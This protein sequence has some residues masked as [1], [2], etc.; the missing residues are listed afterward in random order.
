MSE[1]QAKPVQAPLITRPGASS[2][3]IGPRNIVEFLPTIFQTPANKQFLDATLEQLMSTGSLMAIN[4]FLGTNYKKSAS[5]NYLVDNRA[6]DFYQFTPGVTNRDNENNITQALSYD[7]LINTLDFNEV[8]TNQ[9]NK[10]LNEQGYTLDMPINYDMFINYHN[11]FWLVDILPPC[12]IKPTQANPIDI[13]TLVDDLYYTTPTLSTGN[14]LELMNGMR[15][16]FMPTQIDRFTQTVPGN[17]IFTATVNQ[18]NTVKV[19]KNNQLLEN[20]PSNYTYNTAGGVVIFAVAPAVNDEIEIHSFYAYSSSNDYAVGDIYIV[21]GVGDEGKIR[22][23]KQFTSGQVEGTYSTR[24]WLNHTVYSS[25]EPKGFDEDGTSFEFDPYDIREWRMTTRD[26]VVEKRYSQDVSAWAR[27]NLWIHETAAQAVVNFEGLDQS[28]YLADNFRGVRP[29]IEYKD[30]IEKYNYGRNHIGYVAHLIEDTIDPATQIVGQ[31]IYSHNTYGIT[32]DWSFILGYENGDRVRVNMGGYITYWECIQTHGDPINPT[33]YESRKYWRE[34]TDENLEDGDLVLFLRTTN[35]AYTNRIFRVD[36]VTAGTGI[37]LTEVYGSSSTPLNSGDKVVVMKGYNTIQW[38]DDESTKPYSGSEWYWDGTDWIYGQQKMHRSAGM[39][40]QLYDSVLTKLD[41]T[42]KYPTSTFVGD[43][44]FD[45]GKNTATKF[46]D[47]LGF[48]PRYVDYGNTPGLSFDFGLGGVRYNYTIYDTDTDNSKTL[49]IPGYY[50]YK[51]YHTNRYFNGWSAVRGGQPVRRHIQKIAKTGDTSLTFNLGTTDYNKDSKLSFVLRNNLLTVDSENTTRINQIAGSLPTLYMS[52]NATYDIETYFDQTKLEFL[53]FD[54]SALAPADF[55]RTAGSDNR[56]TVQPLSSTIKAI[57]YRHAD[58]PTVKGAVYFDDDT[59]AHNIKVLK[60]GADYTAFT[61]ASNILTVTGVDVDDVFDVTYHSDSKLSEAEGNFMP[62]DTHIY[63]PQNRTLVDASFG[64]LVAHMREQMQGIPNFTGDYFGLN[65]YDS[66]A[67]THQFGGTIRQQAFSTELLG[68]TSLDTDTDAFSALKYSAQE[69]RRFKSQFALKVAQLHKITKIETPIHEIVDQ[70]L[71]EIHIGKNFDSQFANSNMAMYR[72]YQSQ[73]YTWINTFTPVFDLPNAVNTYDDTENHIQAW[74]ME[75]D[76]S[77]NDVW[78]P[79]VKGV[80]YTLSRTQI[81]VTKTVVFPSSGGAKLHVRWYPQ[82]AVSFTPN[83]AAKLGLVKPHQP[84]LRSDYSKDSTGTATDSV[85]IGHDGSIHVR[86]GTELYNRSA[87]GFDPID[88]ALWDLEL[89]I[90]NNLL[91]LD[92]I[93]L[94]QNIMPNANRLSPNSWADINQ[95]LLPEYNKWKIRN[96]KTSFQSTSYYDVADAFTF[97]Y[98]AVGPGIGGWRGLYTYYFNT[99]R[100]HTHPWEMLG[101][102]TKPT[103]WDANYSWTVPAERT[104]LIEALTYGHYNDPSDTYKRYNRSLAISPSVYNLTVNTLVTSAGV[105]NDPVTAGVVSAPTTTQASKDFVFGDW[106]PTEAEWRRSSEYKIILFIALMR[107]RPLWTLNTF[108]NSKQRK[109]LDQVG[110]DDVQWLFDNTQDLGDNKTPRLSYTPFEDSIVESVRVINGG[111][112]YTSAPALGVYDNF[113]SDASL[114]AHISGGI[115]THVSVD[116]PGSNYYSKP[117]IIASSGSAQFEATL[118]KGARRYFAGLS[119]AIIEFAKYNTTTV[120]QII[121]RFES[122]DYNPILKAGGFVNPSTQQFILESSQDKG[123]TAIPEENYNSFLYISK[124]DQELFIGAIRVSKSGGQFIVNGYDNSNQYFKYNKPNFGGPSVTVSE[125]IPMKRYKEFDQA[126]STIDYN[127]VINTAQEVYDLIHGYDNYLR[128]KGWITNWRSVASQFVYWTTQDSVTTDII[129]MPNTSKLQ[130]EDGDTGYFDTLNKKYDGVYN[131]VGTDGKQITSNRILIERELTNTDDPKTT[132]QV[133]SAEDS[134]LGLRLYKVAVEH[135]VVFDNSTNFDD[136]VFDPALGQLHTR[137]TWKGS[138]TKDWNGKFYSPGYIVDDNSIVQNFDT[139]ARELDQYYGPNNTLGNQQISNVARFNSGYNK[140]QW[141][142]KLKLDDD[143]AFNFVNSSKKYR[144][145]KL[146]VDA[147]MRNNSLFGKESSAD[148]FEQWAVRTG[149]YGDVRSRDTLEFSVSQ[150]LLAGALPAFRFF[151]KEI[152]D[153][154]TDLTV[155]IDQNSDLLVTGSTVNPFDTRDYKNYQQ[156]SQSFSADIDFVNDF[157]TSGLPLLSETDYRVIDKIDF[158]AFPTRNKEDYDFSGVWQNIKQWNNRLNYNY[159][160]KVMYEG[161]TWE[162]LDLDGYSGLNK[163]NDP[164]TITGTVTLP[165]VPSSGTNTLVI[166]GQTISLSKNATTNN[167]NVINLVGTNDIASS[168]VVPHGSTLVVG[169]NSGLSQTITFSNIVTTITYADIDKIGTVTNPVINGSATA[170]L[171]IDGTQVTFDQTQS[172]STNI[173]AQ[174]AYVNGFNTSW[175]QNQS[176][177]SAEA[178]DRINAFNS[179]RV[180]YISANSSADW[181]TWLQDYYSASDAGLNISKLTSELLASP[182]WASDLTAVLDSDVT[183]INNIL[184]KSYTT[185]TAST[186]PAQDVLDSQAALAQGQYITDIKTWQIANPNTVF[187]SST[188]VATATSSGFQTYQ[189]SDIVNRIN[190]AGIPNITAGTDANRL[191]ITKT[192][193]TPS[194][195]FS[196]SISADTSNSDVGF[197]ST[198][199]TINATTVS[200]VTTPNL[201]ITEVVNQINA[202]GIT[203][204]TAQINATNTN[205][206]QINSNNSQL[207]VGTGTA[208]SVI[209]VTTGITLAGTSVTTTPINLGITDIVELINAAGLTSVTANNSNNRLQLISTSPTLIIGAGTANSIVGLTAQTYNATQTTISNVFEALVDAQG[210]PSFIK[211]AN[212]PNIFSIWVANNTEVGNFDKGYAVYQTMDFGMYITKACAGINDGDDAQ[213]MI[214][215]PQGETQA[216]NLNVDDYVFITGSTTVPNIDGI[217]KVTAINPN[218]PLM[219]YIDE[220]IEQEGGIGNVYPLRDVRFSNYASLV[221]AQ[222]DQTN[223]V[224]TYNFSGVRQNNTSTPIYAFVDDDGNGV[225]TVYKWTGGW[226]DTSG[227]TGGVWQVVRTGIRQAKNNLIENVKIYDAKR[228]TTIAQLETW[229]PA[230]GILLGFIKNE[231]DYLVTTDIAVYNYNTLDGEIDT[232]KNWGASKVGK[233]WW[234]LTTSVFLDYEQGSVDYQQNNWGRLFDGASVDIYEWTRSP[235]LPEQWLTEVSRGTVIDGKQASGVPFFEIIDDEVVYSW[236]EETYYNKKTG[237]NET[238]YYFWVKDKENFTGQRLYN[239]SQLAQAVR[240]PSNFDISWCAASGSD[241]LFTSNIARFVTEHCVIQVNKIYESNS[242]PLNEWTLLAEDDPD[243]VIPEYLHIK[244]RDSL[245]GYNNYKQ[246]Y[247][248]TSWNSTT[249]YQPNQV[250]QDGTDYYISLDNGTQNGPNQNQQPSLDT[251]MSHWSKIYDYN[252]PDE[253]QQDDIDVWRGQMIPDLKLHPYN[254]YGH[255]IRPRQSLYRDLVEARQNWVYTV[256]KLLSEIVAVN[257]IVQW[258]SVFNHTFVQGNV[259][260][261]MNKY[262]NWVDYSAAQWVPGTTPDK[263]YDDY[264]AFN[265]VVDDKDGTYSLIKNVVHTDGINRPE[266]YYW[267]NGDRTLVWKSKGTIELSEEMWNQS[268]FGHGY[269]ATGFDITPWDSGSSNSIGK[270]F[271]L[272]REKVFVGSNRHKYN[273]LWFSCLN[274]AVTQNTTDDFAFKTTYVKLRVNHPLLTERDTYENYDITPVEEFVNIIKPFHTKLHTSMRKTTFGEANLIEVEETQRNQIIT[275]RYNDHTVRDWEGDVVLLG[276]E[277][278]TDPDN[279]DS[280]EFTTVDN[281]IEYI[282]NGNDFDQPHEEG[283]GE[284]LYPVDYTE[285]ISIN[286]QT[287][288]SGS[289]EDAD[290]RAFRINMYMP[291]NIQRST[292]IENANKTTTTAEVLAADTT[293]PVNAVNLA[294]FADYGVAWIGSERIEYDA[295]DSD[296]LLYVTRGTLGTPSQ[297]HAS[298]STVIEANSRIPTPDRFAHYEDNLRLAYNDSG[299]SLADPAGGITPEHAFIRNAGQGSI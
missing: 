118:T 24:N 280:M 247:D 291:Q 38:D 77:G 83:S 192:T 101:H 239:T 68:Q 274:Q 92:D 163:P 72:D 147:F 195:P 93:V 19:Y 70:A 197:S 199:E 272:L 264:V 49:E 81:T 1:K 13:D 164:I 169:E 35:A 73:D 185:G 191:K 266:I 212:D 218:N 39:Q 89:R 217:H 286:V 229:D 298:A 21:D 184:A 179:L 209:G 153:V 258:D 51:N 52:R 284:E 182:A 245:A 140:P 32:T 86:N 6:S 143:T 149:D 178:I 293:I 244:M 111:S 287:N 236:S 253:T 220:Y 50:Y 46:D 203:N 99:D 160:D 222:T 297:V 205:L 228:R 133:K 223:G 138:R 256:N 255:L 8:D 29:I 136:I 289:T 79:M 2:E 235:V 198:T 22:L 47:A 243:T 275:M 55:A 127:S 207:Y 242:S 263:T 124:P 37:T 292:V 271:D 82:N 167:L 193:T 240:N 158:A 241:V 142:E 190:S 48:S 60:N 202:A 125:E 200:T 112:G 174:T 107:V 69:Y 113:G 34:I 155:D 114:T 186:I 88:A 33:Y 57:V 183:I 279:T 17:Q 268:K 285:N 168:A 63:N 42:T 74:I 230:K 225:P 75:D 43:Y 95:A 41:D 248:Y 45:Y 196:M 150:E 213:I 40:V 267:L 273:T 94:Y 56:F 139:T 254:R 188:I 87:V 117:T 122:L 224:W 231:I 121:D 44:I 201:T 14:T 128:S 26:Y 159:N 181:V 257:D 58:Y 259:T 250:V 171:T 211:M 18:A 206:L 157:T 187:A 5:D 3:Y 290:S 145:T 115:V 282:Y 281:D 12:S 80:D 91:G 173:D 106:G 215:R 252:L 176:L 36:G 288:A 146:A 137:I 105:L 210:N 278:S 103:W 238:Y 7:D 100:P 66:I 269:D 234:N 141:A 277:L 31:T 27:S 53:A 151:D 59:V 156:S 270:L 265:Q 237:R 9:Q 221:A 299:V 135:A 154:L 62:A 233:R 189:L 175:V 276:G 177:A 116:N 108:F 165:T 134:I 208:N 226:N 84:E 204:I 295:K 98:S 129:L 232:T 120:T 260:Y 162:M 54:G 11:Y 119:N 180:S 85:I 219:F 227:H 172:T 97:N 10:L 61:L 78:K 216:H 170:S 161:R 90:S 28:E 96:N 65:N 15:V 126:V 148:V 194:L 4:N 23:T 20:I 110:Y 152:T 283:W 251:D 76:G 132:I 131:I 123:S 294:N 64:D 104:A 71:K 262:W 166:N 30:G 102:N 67:H 296:N 246:R 16:R 130:I 249:V 25:Q 144:G 261:S 109:F 214:A